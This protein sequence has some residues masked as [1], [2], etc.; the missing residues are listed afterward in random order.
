MKRLSNGRYLKERQLGPYMEHYR[1]LEHPQREWSSLS[2][3]CTTTFWTG[4]S[5]GSETDVHSKIIVKAA[6][7]L[8]PRGERNRSNWFSENKT[9]LF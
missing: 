9:E 7:D 4:G 1:S 6:L 2:P 5:G 3:S 8:Q